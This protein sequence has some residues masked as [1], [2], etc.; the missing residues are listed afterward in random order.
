[1]V[2][3]GSQPSIRIGRGQPIPAQGQSSA[4]AARAGVVRAVRKNQS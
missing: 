2:H 1:M 4:D 3:D